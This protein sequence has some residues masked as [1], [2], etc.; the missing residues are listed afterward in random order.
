M[1]AAVV[2]KRPYTKPTLRE[3]S[4][5]EVER[6]A[7]KHP[8]RCQCDRCASIEAGLP[9]SAVQLST[10]CWRCGGRAKVAPLCLD[11]MHAWFIIAIELCES[12]KADH[13][14][15]FGSDLLQLLKARKTQL[16][17]GAERVDFWRGSG[18][19]MRS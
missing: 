12:A 2:E 7:G 10:S 17:A 3:L 5:A 14:P 13:S 4:P 8:S 9:E 19:R 18:G 16:P 11:C 15:W 6:A 1:R